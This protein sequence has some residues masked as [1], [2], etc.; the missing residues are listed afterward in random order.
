MIGYVRESTNDLYVYFEKGDIH[1]VEVEGGSGLLYDNDMNKL[2]QLEVS[3]E[4]GVKG[5]DVCLTRRE[6]GVYGAKIKIG[7]KRY[8]A[9]KKEEKGIKRNYEER[10]EE[11]GV[12]LLDV[13]KLGVF[14]K[15]PYEVMDELR[16]PVHKRVSL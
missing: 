8:E 3:V 13:S 11:T 5:V 7:P 14:E 6:G 2:G 16:K 15:T 10:L 4:E 12:H 9:L 1:T